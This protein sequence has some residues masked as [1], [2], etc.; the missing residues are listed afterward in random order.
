MCPR[1]T[2]SRSDYVFDRI[3]LDSRI[4]IRYVDTNA[5]SP[6]LWPKA[7]THLM[8]GT[9]YFFCSSCLPFS[10]KLVSK[11]SIGVQERWERSK[12]IVQLWIRW[13]Q[14]TLLQWIRTRTTHQT[15]AR[16]GDRNPNS[17][18]FATCWEIDKELSWF[19]I[20]LPQ[21]GHHQGS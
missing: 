9:N 4:H 6:T 7:V 2:E 18:L 21:F 5:N 11:T 14:G 16:H 1:P 8:N 19:N 20:V 13:V 3:N 10:R 15:H 17:S 12:Q